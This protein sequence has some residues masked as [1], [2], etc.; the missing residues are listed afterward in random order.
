MRCS[1]S[2][3]RRCAHLAKTAR[4]RV[5]AALGVERRLSPSLVCLE[6]ITSE[7]VLGAEDKAPVCAPWDKLI[8]LT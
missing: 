3:H 2:W 8:K 4:V 1:A 5:R 7:T 6:F